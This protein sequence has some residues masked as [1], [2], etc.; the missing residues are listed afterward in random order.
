M[1]TVLERDLQIEVDNVISE[2]VDKST[3]LTLFLN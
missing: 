3:S 1:S 2:S